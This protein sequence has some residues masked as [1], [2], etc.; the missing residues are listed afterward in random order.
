VADFSAYNFAPIM[1]Y[2]D[3]ERMK[4][5]DFTAGYDPDYVGSFKWG[6][7][8][9]DEKRRG[10]YTAPQYENRRNIHMG[11]DIWSEAGQ[12]VFSFYDG[13]ICYKADNQQSGNYGPTLV[14]RYMLDERSLFVLY[15]HLSRAALRKNMTGDRVRKA[16]QI[17]VIGSKEENGGWPPHLHFQL[18][19]H[20]PGKADMPGV[21]SEENRKMALK[22]YPDPRCITGLLY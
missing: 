1:N 9:Y 7:G 19:R 17:A 13:V 18:S 10:M 15:G 12:P 6:I 3:Q 11:I 21:V 16:Q 2:P 5:F 4:V 8:K 14:L 20:D 22:S